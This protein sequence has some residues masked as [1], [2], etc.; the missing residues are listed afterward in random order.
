MA[1]QDAHDLEGDGIIRVPREETPEA[2]E[3]ALA[4]AEREAAVER[5]KDLDEALRDREHETSREFDSAVICA[6][7]GRRVHVLMGCA[8]S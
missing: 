5:R 6:S 7:C 3:A 4:A 8:C 2:L 1:P